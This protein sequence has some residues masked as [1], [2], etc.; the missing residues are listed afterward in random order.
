[1]S[2]SPDNAAARYGLGSALAAQGKTAE[3]ID[4]LSAVVELTPD[5][6]RALNALARLLATAPESK[7]RD[8]RRAVALAER[9]CVL[10]NEGHPLVLDTLAAAY[11]ET[12]DFRNATATAGKALAIARSAG[13]SDMARDIERRM[14]LYSRGVPFRSGS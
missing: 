5:D 8:G 13:R 7:L 3:A 4:Q 1:L 6:A 10:T 12:G 9:A 11:A 2:A 14:E